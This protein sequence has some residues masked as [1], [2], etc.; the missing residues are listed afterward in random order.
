MPGRAIRTTTAFAALAAALALFPSPAGAVAGLPD[1]TF[2]ANGFSIVDEPSLKNEFLN[3]VIVLPDGKIL[4]A[5]A[6]GNLS[7]FLLA[8]LTP[9]GLPDPGF[10]TEG[11]RVED[12]LNMEGNPREIE[13]I[14]ARA[15]GKLVAAGLGRGPGGVGAF[16]FARY[17]PN[18]ELDPTF[19]TSGLTTVPITPSGEAF[20][21]AQT[22]DGKLV[23]AGDNGSGNEAVVVRLTE[24]GE[25]D[26]TFNAAPKGVR[27]VDVPGIA[28]EAEAVQVLSDGTI[29]FGG[30][31]ENGAFLAELDASGKPVMGFGNAGIAVLDLGTDVVPTGE[32][33][34]L[35]VLP[36]GRIL[37]T[38]DALAAPNDEE[39]FV[40][41]FLP[42]GELDP[43]F[44]GGGVFRANPTPEDDETESLEVLPD[45]RILAAGLR[46]E[47]DLGQTADTWLY[48]LTA[49][50]R[51]DMTFGS[52]GEAFASAAPGDD[53]AFGLA[54]QPDGRAVIAGD[55]E[56]PAGSKL[57]FG[58]FLADPSPEPIRAPKAQRCAGRKATI[59][60]TAKADRI[61]GTKRAD[62]I[63]ALG[64]ND[65]ISSGAGND[66]ICA[67]AGNDRVNGGAGKDRLL[68]GA[69]KDG[70]IGGAGPDLCIGGAGRDTAGGSCEQLKRV[71]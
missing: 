28:E 51:R 45:G 4:G 48:R 66:L 36:D 20:S 68:G 37:A 24:D 50:G 41:R 67:G 29:L 57:L 25:P 49:E 15:D 64:G 1:P 53:G 9:A 62:V 47:S 22:P 21:L 23:A 11:I 52:N 55:A 14:E 33:F 10:G 61:K 27:V 70:I 19:G 6:R 34:D 40:A 16:E 43:S 71:P 35:E 39:S 32:I 18:G 2:G 69:G 46:G 56:G 26:P 13:A 60:G 65:R 30:V 8:R 3:D 12:D 44:A 42:N 38:G 7:G 54:L 58:R 63:V 5:G 31:A 17:K 59:V